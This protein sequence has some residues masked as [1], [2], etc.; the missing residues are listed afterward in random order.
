MINV[1]DLEMVKWSW[2]MWMGPRLIFSQG[3]LLQKVI[4]RE[5][6]VVKEAEWTRDS[7]RC[8]SAG[9]EGEQVH[10]LGNETS[11][12]KLEKGFP[13]AYRD[14]TALLTDTLISVCKIHFGT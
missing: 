13:G 12:Q 14:K 2:I 3:L 1:E 6:D 4:V 5:G 7:R 11:L 9:F 8:S 10:E